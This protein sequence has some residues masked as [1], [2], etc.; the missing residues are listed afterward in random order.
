MRRRNS[1]ARVEGDPPGRMEKV[2]IKL[3]VPTLVDGHRGR[4]AT[5]EFNILAHVRVACLERVAGRG[6]DRLDRHDHLELGEVDVRAQ[7]LTEC[8]EAARGR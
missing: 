6:V 2:P 7:G 1:N 8:H 4:K 3:C 5:I